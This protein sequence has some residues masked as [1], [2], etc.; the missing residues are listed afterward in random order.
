[1]PIKTTTS[2]G[3]TYSAD[4]PE[5]TS[6]EEE[7]RL[8]DEAF[9]VQWKANQLEKAAVIQQKAAEQ[10]INDPSVLENIAEIP[11]TVVQGGINAIGNTV[12][13][14]EGWLNKG[15]DAVGFPDKRTEEQK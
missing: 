13:T 11:K 12:E 14:V 7:H 8:M 2:S 6:E 1:M 3:I 9:H 10:E 15:L 5:G 4:I